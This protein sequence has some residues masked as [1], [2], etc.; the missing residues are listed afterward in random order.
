MTSD[1]KYRDK[2][3]N[4]CLWEE[5]INK[6]KKIKSTHLP[7]TGVAKPK[8]IAPQI[9][10]PAYLNLDR[11]GEKERL[12]PLLVPPGPTDRDLGG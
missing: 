8:E 1:T 12:S 4:A 10:S 2:E 7:K 9:F 3:N 6:K 5:R 11:E